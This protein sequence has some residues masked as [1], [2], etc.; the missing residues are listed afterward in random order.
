MPRRL[1]LA[2]DGMTWHE[3][4]LCTNFNNLPQQHIESNAMC[5]GMVPTGV[6]CRMFESHA[7]QRRQTA[8]VASAAVATRHAPK[9]RGKAASAGGTRDW[10]R[11]KAAT[12]ARFERSAGD[13]PAAELRRSNGL[14]KCMHV[15]PENEPDTGQVARH[16]KAA[17]DRSPTEGNTAD[18]DSSH[19][20]LEKMPGALV[21]M[22]LDWHEWFGTFRQQQRIPRN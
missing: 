17:P 11:R 21:N 6:F 10:L 13:V 4:V 9:I 5:K 1:P 20:Q 14:M 7:Q 3:L 18:A 2:G 8:R 16:S 15:L 12:Q 22:C 19:P